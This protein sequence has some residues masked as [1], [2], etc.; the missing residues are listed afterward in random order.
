MA[1]WKKVIVSGSNISELVNDA[2]YL[3]DAQDSA[4]LSGSFSG[5][6]QGDGSGLTGVV[7]QAANA[8]T[9][10][11]GIADFT[12][13]G[14]TASVTVA[15]EADGGTLTVGAD[16][17]KVSDLGIDT[18]QLAADAVDGTKIADDAV[19]SEHIA[20]GAIDFE[21]FSAGSVSGSVV[22]DAS[23]PNTKLV[24]DSVTV[25]TTEIDLGASATTIAGLTSVTSTTFVGDLTGTADS[26]SIAAA[27]APDSVALGT[28]TTGN[29]VQSVANATNGGVTVTNGS[30]EGGD[31]TLALNLNDLSAGV[32]DVAADS[33]AIIDS[34]DSNGTKKES[35]VDLVAGIAGTNLSA[36]SGQLSLSST[37]ANDHTF[38]SNLT[39]QGNLTVEGS[40]INAQVANLDVEDR[41]ILLNSGSATIGD[42]GIVF[43][44]STGTVNEGSALVWDASYNS[45]DGRLGIVADMAGDDTG[46][47]TI[48]YHIAGVYE[49]SEAAAATAQADHVGNI[50]V[51]SSEIYIYV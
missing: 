29:Y 12:Y 32:V 47:Q 17:V 50:R 20:A 26:A 43:G 19:D 7:A 11:N 41:F 5:S 42:S 35:I 46:D 2:N 3:V 21:H 18:D 37:I 49:G 8:L 16:G 38:S 48:A 51:E 34:D 1:E 28:D 15:V 4:V 30:A 36:A 9:D 45:N 40:Q 33:I 10:G 23:L 27:V 6:F 13:D 39:I 22:A 31:A 24:N 44:G 25:G 14:N